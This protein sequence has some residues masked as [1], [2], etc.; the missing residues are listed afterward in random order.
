MD[1]RLEIINVKTDISLN[2]LEKAIKELVKN[3][4]LVG[5]PRDKDIRQGDSQYDNYENEVTNASLMYLHTNGSPL[6]NIPARPVIEAALFAYRPRIVK[7][8][9]QIILDVLTGKPANS[10][11][12][13]VGLLSQNICQDWFD[14]P[15]NNWA[16]NAPMTIALKGSDK[17]LIDTGQLRKSIVYIVDKGG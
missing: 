17:P 16:P 11:F 13:K 15:K 9:K 7:G 12:E 1:T 2:Q 8:M 6:Q 10:G 5:V 3:N 14:D 4:V